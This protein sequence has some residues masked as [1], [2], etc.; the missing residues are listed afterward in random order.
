[1]ET[2]RGLM[3]APD[4]FQQKSKLVSVYS[5]VGR[6]GIYLRLPAYTLQ[7]MRQRNNLGLLE[8]WKENTKENFRI[9]F[10]RTVTFT[11]L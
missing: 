5:S 10:N 9:N 1:M 6:I 7:R 2:R 11:I 8:L 4:D 3:S